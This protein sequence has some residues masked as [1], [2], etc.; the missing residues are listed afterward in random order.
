MLQI[1]SYYLLG[2]IELEKE[3]ETET[4]RDRYDGNARVQG[5]NHVCTLG[6]GAKDYKKGRRS[7]KRDM[8]LYPTLH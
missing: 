3:T 4:V 6:T 8:T 2:S 7:R 1:L 5:W